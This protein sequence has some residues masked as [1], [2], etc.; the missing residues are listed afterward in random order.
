MFRLITGLATPERGH[1]SFTREGADQESTAAGARPSSELVAYM[2][3]ED[4]LL[5]WRTARENVAL[6][7]ELGLASG[8]KRA[9]RGSAMNLLNEVG[10]EDAAELYPHALSGGMRQR[11]ALARAL[12]QERP[13]LLLDEP[14]G[15]LDVCHREQMYRLVKE[16]Q[17]RHGVS[18]LLITH[19]FRD[20]LILS[21]RIVLLADGHI[22]REW[23]IGEGE[24]DDPSRRAALHEE[25]RSAM[26]SAAGA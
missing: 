13:L 16:V 12:I 2:M 15:A 7:V 3:Q 1:I 9:A 8:G 24:G 10:L 18:V 6:G 26:L 23:R 14:F 22:A 5:P 17:R 20:A 4:L 11:V 21:D 19:D 25:L